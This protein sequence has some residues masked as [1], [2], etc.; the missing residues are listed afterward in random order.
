M[1]EL[2]FDEFAVVGHDRGARVAHR[3]TLDYPHL[4]TKLA[5]LDIVPTRHALRTADL[6]FGLAYWHWFFLAQPEPLPEHQIGAD[7]VGWVRGRMSSWRRGGQPFDEQAVNEYVRCFR[8]PAAI[9]A[10][11]EDYRAAVGTDL[12][13]RRRRRGPRPAR[14]R[15]AARPLG[16]ARLRRPPLRRRG[17]GLAR[18]RRHRD[19]PLAAL[20]PLP[21][22][23][24]PARDRR[25]PPGL[26][27]RLSEDPPRNDPRNP[28]R[29]RDL[30]I[31]LLLDRVNHGPHLIRRSA[32]RP[33]GPKNFRSSSPSPSSSSDRPDQCRS[34]CSTTGSPS[35][36]VNPKSSDPPSDTDLSSSRSAARAVVVPRQPQQPAGRRVDQDDG[37]QPPHGQ[38]R[39]RHPGDRTVTGR[40]DHPVTDPAVDSTSSPPH[41]RQPSS[42]D[43]S[44]SWAR[45]PCRP[46]S[47]ALAGPTCTSSSY[48]RKVRCPSHA[49]VSTSRVRFRSLIFRSSSRRRAEHA[50]DPEPVPPADSHAVHR[51]LNA[52]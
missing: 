13:R 18:V 31:H 52:P 21:G 8:Q 11:C 1:R 49:T 3:L 48:T 30:L 42:H 17:R 6:E 20:R 45:L 51:V 34:G 14:H 39:Q 7:P 43:P 23:R 12:A 15:P 40:G 47:S 28:A 5:V 25:R 32:R 41:S 50:I 29:R 44:T 2:G 33:S 38:Q 46:S 35:G 26:P 4:V 9:H 16:R 22:R 36:G 19:R 37:G 10:S 24:G 27:R